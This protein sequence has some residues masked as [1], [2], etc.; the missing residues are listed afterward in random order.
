MPHLTH[1]HPERFWLVWNPAGHAPTHEHTAEHR[2]KAE[3]SRLAE[4]NPGQPFYVLEATEHHMREQ[5]VKVTTLDHP[6]PF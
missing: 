1:P 4:L 3:A 2:A 5:P 6:I